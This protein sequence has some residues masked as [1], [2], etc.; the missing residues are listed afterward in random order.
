[1]CDRR[2]DGEC[3]SPQRFA[4]SPLGKMLTDIYG[5]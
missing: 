1:V 2:E 4:D 3:T 5:E